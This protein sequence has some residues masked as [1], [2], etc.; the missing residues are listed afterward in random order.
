MSNTGKYKD[1]HDHFNNTYIT[2]VYTSDPE[3]YYNAAMVARQ[4]IDRLEVDGVLCRESYDDEERK[5]D[6]VLGGDL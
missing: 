3:M 4:L 5:V 1:L 6:K 2:A